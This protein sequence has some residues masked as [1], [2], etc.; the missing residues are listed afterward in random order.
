MS[1]AY[2]LLKII[3]LLRSSPGHNAASLA[4]ECE[5]SERTIY[6]D[7]N[8][9]SLLGVPLYYGEKGYQLHSDAF[10]PSL[11]F[12]LEELISLRIAISSS[13]LERLS[14][15]NKQ[16]RSAMLKL[17]HASR[18]S[19][20]GVLSLGEPSVFQHPKVTA[21]S[22]TFQS[23]FP[24]LER[25]IR[26]R[27]RIIINYSSLQ[28][29]KLVSRKVDPYALTFRRHAWYLVAFCHVRGEMRLFRADRIR[30]LEVTEEEY[31]R[32][33]NFSLERFF[34]DSWELYQGEL[35]EVTVKFSPR[36]AHFLKETVHHHN[37]QISELQD[38]GILYTVRVKGLEEVAR[39][40]FG[41]GCEAEVLKPKSLRE[42]MK[43]IARGLA[44]IY[45]L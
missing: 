27:R 3:S 31:Q 16:L 45:N 42:E 43:R 19:T 30:S 12:T 34:T 25:S 4:R 38:G 22:S 13:L 36:V 15:I 20:Y 35:V 18:S 37:E 17:S 11:N 1:R 9:L 5:V 21:K 39:W 23:L 44:N 32:D 28:R 10:L 26:D 24:S 2:R 14:P 29:R 7:L 41:F 33:E 6:R 8:E 40:I